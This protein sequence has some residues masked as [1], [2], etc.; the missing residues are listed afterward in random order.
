MTPTTSR[1]VDGLI[2]SLQ[3]ATDNVH[4]QPI[5]VHPLWFR[6]VC[7][8]CGGYSVAPQ[9]STI[10]AALADRIAHARTHNA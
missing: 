2:R 1:P 4:P 10:A 9:R 8:P 6:V 7:V 3:D 5:L